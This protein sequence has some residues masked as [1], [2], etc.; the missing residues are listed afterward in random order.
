MVT[1]MKGLDFITSVYMGGCAFAFL[2]ADRNKEGD[3]SRK[4]FGGCLLMFS[5]WI[6]IGF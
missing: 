5:L 6:L 4:F 2:F 1:A 3:V